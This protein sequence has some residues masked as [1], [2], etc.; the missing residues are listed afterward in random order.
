MQRR[1]VL[2][3]AAASMAAGWAA[4]PAQAH[5]Q[6]CPSQQLTLNGPFPPGGLAALVDRAVAEGLGWRLGPPGG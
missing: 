5:T 6:A 2:S 4:V 3:L 1:Q